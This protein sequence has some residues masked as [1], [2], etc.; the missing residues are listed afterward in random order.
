VST[1]LSALFAYFDAPANAGTGL[2]HLVFNLNNDMYVLPAGVN[3]VDK[4]PPYVDSVISNP[5]GTVTVA[6]TGFGPDSA[7]YFDSLPASVT[8]ECVPERRLR[9]LHD[10]GHAALGRERADLRRHGLQRRRAELDVPAAIRTSRRTPTR[11][12]ARRSCRMSVRR[13]CRPAAKRWSTSPPPTPVLRTGQVTVGFGTSDI[14]V[15]GVWVIGPT[16]LVANVIVAPGAALGSSEIS[17]ISGFQVISQPLG[18]QIVAANPAAPAILAVVNGVPGQATIYPKRS[19]LSG[20][21]T[22][23]TRRSPSAHFQC[24]LAGGRR[25][26]LG[27]DRLLVGRS[28][29][30]PGASQYTIGPAILT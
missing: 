22:W 8:P 27:A 10:H 20:A 12:T 17:V 29:E 3:L 7:V 21:P 6:G 30:C 4:Q 18:F 2:R 5:D 26:R 15:T 9:R 14:T 16:H 28:G 25:Q 11:L 19:P 23:P 1:P 24:R 13:R